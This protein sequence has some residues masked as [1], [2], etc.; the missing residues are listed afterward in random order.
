MSTAMT[1]QMFT[2]RSQATGHPDG[3]AIAMATGHMA[4]RRSRDLCTAG[5]LW[6]TTGVATA[7]GVNFADE[8]MVSLRE[9]T[10]RPSSFYEINSVVLPDFGDYSAR[11]NA[12]PG[13]PG[14][15]FNSTQSIDLTG[16]LITRESYGKFGLSLGMSAPAAGAVPLASDAPNPAS[17]D[18]GVRWRSQRE[19]GP[20]FDVSAWART[21]QLA[22]SSDAL[23]MIRDA[24]QPLYG[25]RLEVQWESSKTRGLVPEFGAVGVQLQGGS[26][27][28]LRARKG[29][30]M[31]YYRSR[32]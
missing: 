29:G 25:T 9:K 32:F 30:P 13:S 27:L 15:Q 6:L 21:S 26:R 1:V 20:Q 28:L 19:S 5:L 23:T 14:Y 12:L 11:I 17:V 22:P 31:L 24:Q 18:F 2:A 16:W 4:H 3:Y 10:T 8:A 7:A